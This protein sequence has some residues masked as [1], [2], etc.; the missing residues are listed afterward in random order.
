M[1]QVDLLLLHAPSVYDF[2]QQAIMY[3]PISDLIPSSPVFEMYPLGFLTMTNYLEERGLEVR[4]VNLALRM[5]ND[6]NL[7]VPD[8]L[9]KLNPKAFGI[10]LHWLPHAHGAL[11]VA[12]LIKEIH[13][14]TPIIFGGLSSTYFHRQ[15]LEYPQVDYVLRGDSIEPPLYELLTTLDAGQLAGQGTQSDLEVRRADTYQP[16][17]L[18]TRHPRLRR[19][20]SRP[21]RE[22]GHALPRSA[23]CVAF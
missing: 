13:P 10:D 20:A 11:E 14:Q 9:A 5:M 22:N 2:R 16:A 17:Q 8:F 7:D 12:K 4:I 6:R 21:Y 15:L 1:S 23:K 18:H 19:S 3:G